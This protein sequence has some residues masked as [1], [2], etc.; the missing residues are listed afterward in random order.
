MKRP[1]EAE[2]KQ[3][4]SRPSIERTNAFIPFAREEIEQSI[5]SRFEQQVRLYPDRLAVKTPQHSW[6]YDERN[7]LAN[8]VAQTILALNGTGRTAVVRLI[9]KSAAHIEALQRR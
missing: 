3:T 9:E 2:A 6:T 5:P 4:A 7:R 1:S 8:R